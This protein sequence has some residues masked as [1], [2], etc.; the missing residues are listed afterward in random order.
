MLRRLYRW[1]VRLHPASFR[2]RFGEEML[3]IFDQ[4]KGTRAALHIALDCVLSLFRQRLLRPHS[5]TELAAVPLPSPNP[6]SIPSFESLDPFQPRASAVIPGALL[7]LT[8]F[9]L[10]V[11]GISYSWIHVLRPRF[12]EVGIGPSQAVASQT[13]LPFD[14]IPTEPGGPQARPSVS[15]S[16]VAAPTPKPKQ[17]ILLDQYVGEYISKDPPV[18]ILVQIEE[19]SFKGDHLSISLAGAAHSGLALSPMSPGKFIVAGVENSH[20]IFTADAQGSICCLSWV[21][22]GIVTT[23]RRQ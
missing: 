23:A 20:V 16:S 11:I 18:K 10:T 7:S 3:S 8:L 6:N 13:S 9:Y 15:S 5:G 17:M 2:R 1:A 4:Q 12:P 14:V 21:V 19:D 22:N